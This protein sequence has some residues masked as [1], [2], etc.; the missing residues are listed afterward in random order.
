MGK[1][2][3]KIQDGSDNDVRPAINPDTQENRMINL[4]INLAEKQLREGTASSQVI[5]HYLKLGT[6]LS[7]LERERLENENQL[8]RAKTKAY[9]SAENSERMYAEALAAFR[10]YTGQG[11]TTYEDIPGTD[12][13]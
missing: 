7:R 6:S 11:E 8:I 12:D 2:S 4:A 9:E 3:R 10:V 1:Q 13:V 5:T